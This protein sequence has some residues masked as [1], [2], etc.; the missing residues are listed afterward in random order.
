MKNLRHTPL[1]TD[2][3]LV[4]EFCSLGARGVFSLETRMEEFSDMKSALDGAMKYIQAMMRKRGELRAKYR[5][6]Y[7]NHAAWFIEWLRDRDM[8]RMHGRYRTNG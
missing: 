7:P 4:A 2:A 5:R 8:E 1:V 3:R 6:I